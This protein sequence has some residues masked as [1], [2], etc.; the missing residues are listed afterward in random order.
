MLVC[1]LMCC[2]QPSLQDEEEDSGDDENSYHT[3]GS[4]G[5]GGSGGVA[6]GQSEPMDV[7]GASQEDRAPGESD[8]D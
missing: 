2:D 7:Q 8:S 4:R 1:N 6:A 3:L 5:S